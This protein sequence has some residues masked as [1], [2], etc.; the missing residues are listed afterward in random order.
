MT[1]ESL[2]VSGVGVAVGDWW[3][4]SKYGTYGLAS[5]CGIGVAVAAG[6]GVDTQSGS[7]YVFAFSF[8]VWHEP[9][10]KAQSPP[11]LNTRKRC[12]MP[13]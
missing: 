1:Q 3:C 8:E 4:L 11:S 10:K 7:F 6:V 5:V 13:V 9:I 12:Q 2:V